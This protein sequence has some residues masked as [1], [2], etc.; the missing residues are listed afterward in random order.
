MPTYKGISYKVTEIGKSVFEGCQKLKKVVIG[1]N[2]KIIGDKAF[3]KC[4]LLKLLD[5]KSGKLKKA[6][7]NV[8]GETA[9]D[10]EIKAPAGKYNKYLKLFKKL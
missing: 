9:E 4:K 7:K 1:K 2:I 6:G 5:I 8:I 10:L 3:Y